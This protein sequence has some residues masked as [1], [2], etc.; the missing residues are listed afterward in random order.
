MRLTLINQFYAPD[1]SPT[2]HLCASLAEHRAACGD[3]VTV[4]TSRSGYVG[5]VSH[6]TQTRGVRVRRVWSTRLGSRTRLSRFIDWLMFYLSAFWRAIRLGRQDA[7]ICLTTPPYIAWAGIAHKLLHGGRTRLIL[8]N[9]DCYPEAVERTGMLRPISYLARTMR[10]MNRAIFRRIDHLICLDEA[11]AD[12]LSVYMPQNNSHASTATI[13]KNSLALP[14]S[15][16]P[17]WE[18]L[19]LFSSQLIPSPEPTEKNHLTILYLGN[20]GYGHDFQTMIDAARLLRLDP[21]LFRFVG[22]G[23]RQSWIQAH[24]RLHNLTN[25]TLEDY[26]PK[27]QTPAIMAQADCALITLEDPML[28][29]MSPSKLHANLAMGLPIIYVGPQRSNVDEAI[30][31]FGCGIS[32]RPGDAQ[33]LA[34]FARKLLH[35]PQTRAEFRHRARQAFEEAYCDRVALPKFD[36]VLDRIH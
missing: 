4:I 6:A 30:E 10:A 29:V 19:D 5:S 17:N 20:A 22:G 28:G 2:A 8:W 36:A 35:E 27:E 7:I 26:V 34:D 32:L 13:S 9:M 11:M 24:K 18:P 25:I 14:C 31:R 33:G 15:I 23:A 16:I 1:L 3:R 21:I 12:L